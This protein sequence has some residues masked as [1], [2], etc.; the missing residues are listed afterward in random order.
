MSTAFSTRVL[1]FM[2]AIAFSYPAGGLA[3]GIGAAA[4]AILVAAVLYQSPKTGLA[5][6]E[7]VERRPAPGKSKSWPRAMRFPY[8]R[9]C[10]SL[11]L[12]IY[13]KAYYFCQI[14]MEIFI[15]CVII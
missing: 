3:S 15:C 14:S 10:R 2:C 1:L 12:H 9:R 8:S 13:G 7:S 6:S 5:S 11:R 4:A